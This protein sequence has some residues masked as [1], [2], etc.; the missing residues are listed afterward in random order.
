M[1]RIPSAGIVRAPWEDV[2]T[3]FKTQLR[4]RARSDT[5]KCALMREFKYISN[6]TTHIYG[7]G[8]GGSYVKRRPKRQGYLSRDPNAP[9]SSNAYSCGKK[10]RE[11]SPSPWIESGIAMEEARRLLSPLQHPCIHIMDAQAIFTRSYRRWYI[12][13]CKL[14]SESAR[15]NTSPSKDRFKEALAGVAGTVA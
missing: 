9:S 12:V 2:L 6:R 3:L 14:S 1:P 4:L 10:K 15:W 8:T 13:F 5:E 11:Q 7:I